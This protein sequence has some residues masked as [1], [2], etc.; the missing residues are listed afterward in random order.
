VTGGS[1]RVKHRGRAV[2]FA[3]AQADLNSIHWAAFYGDCEHEVLEVTNG[4]RITLTYNLYY[5]SIGL[6]ASPVAD[7]R[8]FPLYRIAGD[9]LRE[10]DFMPRGKAINTSFPSSDT[11]LA[12]RRYH[13]LLLPSSVCTFPREE[14]EVVAGGFQGRRSRR[15][16]GF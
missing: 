1:L 5:S 3:W 14:P 16:F 2:D 11:D 6:S 10:A 4:Y 13:R 7:T 15:I 9:A 12:N 8:H